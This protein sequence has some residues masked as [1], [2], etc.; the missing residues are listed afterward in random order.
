MANLL[1]II[2][3]QLV[4]KSITN[5]IGDA[6]I[7]RQPRVFAS[8]VEAGVPLFSTLVGL[9]GLARALA[10]VAAVVT[11]GRRVEVSEHVALAVTLPERVAALRCRGVL[12]VEVEQ[13]AHEAVAGVAR[14]L[15]T[16]AAIPTAFARVQINVFVAV[17]HA[18]ARPACKVGGTCL[19]CTGG[20]VVVAAVF[21][22][23]TPLVTVAFGRVA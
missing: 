10:A 2:S 8:G 17:T 15:A 7:A 19:V 5:K 23:R 1:C 6:H 16:I 11:A 3:N 4:A 14:G 13:A 12:A 18:V 22:L 20:V 21:L 9:G